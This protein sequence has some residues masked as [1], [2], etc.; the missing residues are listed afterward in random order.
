MRT[1]I[2]ILAIIF[3]GSC[4]ESIQTNNSIKELIDHVKESNNANL[5]IY[6]EENKLLQ[7]IK[8]SSKVFADQNLDRIEQLFRLNNN[9]PIN[10]QAISNYISKYNSNSG[11]HCLIKLKF[12]SITSDVEYYNI[13]NQLISQSCISPGTIHLPKFFMHYTIA[14]NEFRVRKGEFLIIPLK[15]FPQKTFGEFEYILFD[16]L[17]F[18]AKSEF[19]GFYSIKTDKMNI[20]NVEREL[21]VYG[22][23]IYSNMVK[24]VGAVYVVIEIY[25]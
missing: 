21:K 2:T 3:L 8:L 13:L 4:K 5:S 16:T 1:I 12:K 15:A 22:K 9:I 14:D 20:G 7:K 6:R 24:E 11:E 18:T 23:D 17:S 10:Y 25:E 19:D